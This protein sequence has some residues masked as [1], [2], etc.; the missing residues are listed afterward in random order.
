MQQALDSSRAESERLS[1][2]L[3]RMES[4]SE[5]ASALASELEATKMKLLKTEEMNGQL[6]SELRRYLGKA[7]TSKHS[8]RIIL[9]TLGQAA[10]TRTVHKRE[11]KRSSATAAK[12]QRQAAGA[13]GDEQH[14]RDSS[15]DDI[16]TMV[17]ESH[18]GGSDG[19]SSDSSMGSEATR[20]YIA[21]MKERDNM[22]VLV[23]KER[24]GVC[25]QARSPR[26]YI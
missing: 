18:E 3:R 10:G 11:R 23:R 19:E 2:Q 26:A 25:V 24:P 14:K 16:G 8:K 4:V 9:S 15:L 21:A 5:S 6:Q 22:R 1:Q 20:E 17:E 13:G 7:T 12:K